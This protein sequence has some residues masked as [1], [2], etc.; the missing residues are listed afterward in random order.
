ME[1][2]GCKCGLY[3]RDTELEKKLKTEKALLEQRLQLL[4]Q[5]RCYKAHIF[6]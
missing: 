6:I 4:E 5:G 3:K 1:E 2:P